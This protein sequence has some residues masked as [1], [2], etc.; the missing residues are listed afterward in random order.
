[1][2]NLHLQV[3]KAEKDVD[4]EDHRISNYRKES[5]STEAQ[6]AKRIRELEHRNAYHEQENEFLKKQNEAIM[7]TGDDSYGIFA[8]ITAISA[9]A[10]VLSRKKFV[11]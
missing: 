4:F 5:Q 10:F 3:Q 1:M 8:T 7:N 9:I 2:K 6:M 11:K